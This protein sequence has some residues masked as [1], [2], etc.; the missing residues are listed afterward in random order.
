[1]SAPIVLAP[2]C[3]QE[4]ERLPLPADAAV[5][6]VRY[7]AG[8][9]LEVPR[10]Q[11]AGAPRVAVYLPALRELQVRGT[12]VCGAARTLAQIASDL[13]LP[14]LLRQTAAACATPAVR[15]LATL[16]GNVASCRPGCLAVALLA[17]D[18]TMTICRAGTGLHTLT[19]SELLCAASVGPA[20]ARDLFVCA[21]WAGHP[22]MS[23]MQRV[24]L[25]A[26]SGPVL[27]TVA[28]AARRHRGYLRWN[29][30]VGG[31][32]V[33]PQRLEHAEHML[34]AGTVVAPELEAVAA[35]EVGVLPDA[36]GGD[37]QY[38]RHVIGVLV[39]RA[40]RDATGGG[41]R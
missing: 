34:A 39:G 35:R 28:V 10:W 17:L 18:A 4:L 7:V 3:L 1:M 19:L 23:A 29:V 36:A 5:S 41:P 16:G 15:T 27:A 26:A 6:E 40:V 32:T 14:P 8:G 22:D 2:S 21:A 20:L 25:Q 9:T 13:V 33:R 30:A 11:V 37:E 12:H 38:Q 24:N 31:R